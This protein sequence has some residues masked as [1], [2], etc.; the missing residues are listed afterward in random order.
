MLNLRQILQEEGVTPALSVL[1]QLTLSVTPASLPAMSVTLFLVAGLCGAE[2]CPPLALGICAAPDR[3][4]LEH[5]S[6]HSL[7][8][9]IAF[10]S[11]PLEGFYSTAPPESHFPWRADR[12]AP[13]EL[14]CHPVS[15]DHALQQGLDL[16]LRGMGGRV[17]L[18]P[19][20]GV[21]Q[22]VVSPYSCDSCVLMS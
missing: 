10:P 8:Q 1:S 14:S 7:Q 2:I 22:I 18:W 3:C 11:D 19:P 9:P 21:L 12:Y 13:R 17:L 4:S 20:I 16:S 6:N 15:L 5:T